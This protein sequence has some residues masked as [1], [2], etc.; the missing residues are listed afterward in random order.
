MPEQVD[1]LLVGGRRFVAELRPLLDALGYRV[2]LAEDMDQARRSMAARRYQLALVDVTEARGWRRSIGVLKRVS[3][4]TAVIAVALAPPE[5]AEVRSAL[6]AGA[7]AV[8]DRPLEPEGVRSVFHP[9]NDGMLV[10]V[11]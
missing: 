11:R 2:G 8:L 5:E 10:V 3:R 7:Y 1:A 6:S 4:D 9:R